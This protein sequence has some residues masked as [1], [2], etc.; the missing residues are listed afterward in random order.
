MINQITEIYARSGESLINQGIKEAVLPISE[1]ENFLRILDQSGFIILGGDIYKKTPVDFE[2]TYENWFY[3]EQDS[4]ESIVIAKEY[5]SRFLD[6][7]IFISFIL[8]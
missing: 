8:K 4:K 6:E 2:Y 1:V 7:N 3:N 5:L